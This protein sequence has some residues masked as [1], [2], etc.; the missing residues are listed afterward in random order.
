MYDRWT[1]SFWHNNHS[2]IVAVLIG[3][4]TRGALSRERHADY[5]VTLWGL[6]LLA[7]AAD[8]PQAQSIPVGDTRPNIVLVMTDDQGFGDFGFCAGGGVACVL[9]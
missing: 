7:C 3:I 5:D 2:M 9:K 6:P 8:P 4:L 1:G